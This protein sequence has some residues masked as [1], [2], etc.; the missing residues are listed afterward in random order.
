MAASDTHYNGTFNLLKSAEIP[1][2]L[3]QEEGGMIP[4]PGSE[5]AP[6]VFD[7]LIE[8]KSLQVA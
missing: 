7:S 3:N 1:T 8:S 6:R 4:P 5:M 2:I